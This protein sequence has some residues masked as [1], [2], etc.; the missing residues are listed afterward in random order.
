MGDNKDS[1]DDKSHGSLR[2][3]DSFHHHEEAE[4]AGRCNDAADQLLAK[5]CV[6]FLCAVDG[7]PFADAAVECTTRLM[8]K[9]SHV[10]LFHAFSSEE[11]K[12]LPRHLDSE[13]LK[14]KYD[15][16]MLTSLP[17][18]KYTLVWEDRFDNESAQTLPVKVVLIRATDGRIPRCT[19]DF[20]VVGYSGLRNHLQSES[21]D[22]H[23]LSYHAKKTVCGSIADFSMRYV[24]IPIIIVKKEIPPQSA[25]V[26]KSF[27]MA[28]DNS[29][30][31]KKGLD[32]VY[33]LLT[34]R[35]T[36]TVIHVFSDKLDNFGNET[37]NVVR[38]YYEED[39]ARYSPT[40]N[41]AFIPLMKEGTNLISDTIADYVNEKGADFFCIAPR[42][43][44][45][46]AFASMTEQMIT[47]V[48][49]NIVVCKLK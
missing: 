42:V 38:T 18:S 30:I 34:P 23:G 46:G 19:S 32:I 1:K 24:H 8:K 7:S 31:S 29:T 41:C 22:G 44:A 48:H 3:G 16:M 9:N 47:R 27:I 2:R 25:G 4:F 26:G 15:I 20:L 36:L 37:G 5:G 39:M 49:T 11:D 14:E 13:A 33:N 21:K 35:D 45:D 43:R 10:Y 12:E 28:V 6:R 40:A 17:K